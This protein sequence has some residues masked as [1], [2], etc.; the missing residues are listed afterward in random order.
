MVHRACEYFHGTK[1]SF[2]INIT[3]CG[4]SRPR[5]W[6]GPS[7]FVRVEPSSR[8]VQLDA[9]RQWMFWQKGRPPLPEGWPEPCWRSLKLNEASGCGLVGPVRQLLTRAELDRRHT[10]DASDFDKS[11]ILQRYWVEH[12]YFDSSGDPSDVDVVVG[13]VLTTRG[14]WQATSFSL[15]AIGSNFEGRH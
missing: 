15:V 13:L 2:V 6:L 10:L 1:F 5:L 3:A 4:D 11:S 12:P 14:R 9:A 8:L 7:V